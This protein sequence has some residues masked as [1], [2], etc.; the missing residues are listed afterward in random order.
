MTLLSVESLTAGYGGVPVLRDVSAD[1]W[2]ET[3]PKG[4][5][6]AVQGGA[7]AVSA[8]DAVAQALAAIHIVMVH[9][10]ITQLKRSFPMIPKESVHSFSLPSK[11]N[12]RV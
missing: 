9:S 2:I 11:W 10:N 5:L 7:K 4:L 3:G 8:K 6:L 12:A 1:I